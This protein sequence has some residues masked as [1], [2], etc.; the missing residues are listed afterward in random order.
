MINSIF[1]R[2]GWKLFLSYLI[3]VLAS[4]FVFSI[5]EKFAI[6]GAFDRHMS[7]MEMM[8]E[9]MMGGTILESDSDIFTSFENAFNETITVAIIFAGIIAILLSVFI[10]RKLTRPIHQMM[11]ASQR[12]AEGNYKERVKISNLN[13]QDEIDQLAIS[14]NQMAENLEHTEKMRQQLI[15]DVAH[16]LR[17]PLTTI[18]GSMEGLIDGVLPANPETFQLLFREAERMQTLINDLQEL[19]RVE[20]GIYKLDL[21]PLPVEEIIQTIYKRLEQQFKDKG[22]ELISKIE[23]NI[24]SLLVD[25]NRIGQVMINLVGNALQYTASG[26]QVNIDAYQKDQEIIISITDTGIGIPSE[27]LSQIFQ[28]FYR[29]DKSRSRTHG[30]SGIGLTISK[31]IIEAHGGRI[32]VESK[33]INFGS[34]FLFTLPSKFSNK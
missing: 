4:V 1:N 19:S 9:T 6:P 24:P 32:W 3:I 15:G 13:S 8:S 28:R 10:A 17:T 12:I 23:K 20:A 22:V 7:S 25:E 34:K 21:H 33:G 26:G 29:V 30:G 2:L 14:F 31:H 11:L 27:H 16:E 5:A 18:K